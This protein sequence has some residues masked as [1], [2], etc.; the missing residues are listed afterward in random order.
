MSQYTANSQGSLWIFGDAVGPTVLDAH[1]ASFVVRM[2]DAKQEELVPDE[3]L[4][5]AKRIITLPE[6]T[7]VMHG[8]STMW[9]KSYGHVRDL[10]DF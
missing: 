7:E 5:Y 3:L 6:W 2:I 9:N 10:Q 4:D 8:R 1:F